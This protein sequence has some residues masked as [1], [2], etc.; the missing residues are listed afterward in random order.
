MIE[1]DYNT[2]KIPQA[3]QIQK[4]LQQQINVQP[5]KLGIKTIGGADIS[6]NMFSKTVYAGIV[7]LSYPDMKLLGYSLLQGETNFPYIAGYLAFREVPT[8]SKV[9]E[10]MP[11]KPDVLVVDGHGIAH[12][13]RLGIA[14]HF[15]LVTGQAT[16][17]CAKK[18]LFGKFEEP[19]LY[20]GAYA[21]IFD[22][23]EQIGYALRSKDKALPVY[24]S[25]GHR[26]SMM[27]SLDIAITSLG[28]YRIPEPTRLA[29]ETVNRF[30]IGELK[31]GWHE[32]QAYGQL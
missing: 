18:I 26:L 15:G 29:H 11:V 9:W 1:Y 32:V 13:R 24:I 3:T 25:P 31:A 22:R 27:E 2:L 7:L 16:M 10:Q 20:R 17:G 19:S 23:Q 28:K 8:L 4:E 12:P 6:L 5:R 14:T 21:P 30:R